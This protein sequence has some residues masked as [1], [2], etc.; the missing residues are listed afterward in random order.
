M[1]RSIRKYF[2][3]Y[4]KKYLARA[5]DRKKN[6]SD[7]KWLSILRLILF[8]ICICM[9]IIVPVVII[10]NL[11]HKNIITFL[12]IFGFMCALSYAWVSEGLLFRRY[13]EKQRSDRENEHSNLE[14]NK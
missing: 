8:I 6:E 1:I 2:D 3:W 9:F 13:V 7:I 10:W 5:E 12:V 14:T 11:L 4:D